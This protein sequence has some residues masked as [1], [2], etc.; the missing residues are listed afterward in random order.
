MRKTIVVLLILVLV[1]PLF[2]SAVPM[3][4]TLKGY[5]KL[6]KP[7]M[8]KTQVQKITAGWRLVDMADRYRKEKWFRWIVGKGG[9]HKDSQMFKFVS[10]YDTRFFLFLVFDEMEYLQQYYFLIL[11][12]HNVTVSSFGQ[13]RGKIQQELKNPPYLT[14]KENVLWKYNSRMI[15]L[16]YGILQKMIYS[17]GVFI[18]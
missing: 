6:F 4:N 11:G 10:L 12:K 16:R 18:R 1:V 3:P 13:L 15:W 7:R 2:S 8:T 9:S 14:V 5:M 17:T